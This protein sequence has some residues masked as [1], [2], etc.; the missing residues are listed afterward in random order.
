MASTSALALPTFVDCHRI[1]RGYCDTLVILR[2]SAV[3]M[4]L[5]YECRKAEQIGRYI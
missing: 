1:Y 5:V 4:L 3:L 2:F